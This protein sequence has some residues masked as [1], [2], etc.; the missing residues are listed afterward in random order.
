[1]VLLALICV[2]QKSR[3]NS[4]CFLWI[5]FYLAWQP[6]SGS[7]SALVNPLWKHRQHTLKVVYH[8]CP[9]YFFYLFLYFFGARGQ[10]CYSLKENPEGAS[11]KSRQL[12]GREVETRKKKNAV[13]LGIGVSKKPRDRQVAPWQPRLW[14]SNGSLKELKKTSVQEAIPGSASIF[15]KKRK[16]R[17][18]KKK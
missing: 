17:F 2:E 18:K 11:C 16:S 13:Y 10:F 12:P 5:W 14:W 15:N 6:H 9:R 7:P 3:E 1:M 8:E 4:A